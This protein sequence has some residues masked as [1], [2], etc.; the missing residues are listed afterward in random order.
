MYV[1]IRVKYLL[2]HLELTASSDFFT[3]LRSP[4]SKTFTTILRD[5]ELPAIEIRLSHRDHWQ[6]EQDAQM[7]L[8]GGLSTR[9]GCRHRSH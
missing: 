9:S 8:R 1:G 6:V 3:L 4:R 7:L 5:G 2:R